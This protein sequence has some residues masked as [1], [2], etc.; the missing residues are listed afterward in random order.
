MDCHLGVFLL[1]VDQRTPSGTSIPVTTC[2]L[3]LR[4]D[5]V[6][7]KRGSNSA[8]HMAVAGAA[9]R[10]RAAA[11]PA[12][13]IPDPDGTQGPDSRPSGPGASDEGAEACP[14]RV[15][16]RILP[17]PARAPGCTRWP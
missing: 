10:Q 13:A 9:L 3:A 7:N 4:S 14:G 15:P 6:G 8:A 11:A 12:E 1:H 16:Q 5:D 2:A 17:A